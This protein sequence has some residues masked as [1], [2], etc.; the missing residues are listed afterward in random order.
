MTSGCDALSEIDSAIA[1]A[2]RRLARA[3]DAAAAD[4]R[5]LAE[6][7]H[8]EIGVYHALAD[9]RLIH[10]QDDA[11]NGGSLGQVDRRAEELIAAHEA[12]VADLAAARD[13]AAGELER[14]EAARAQAETDV[15][16]AVARHEE[17]A[18]TTRAGLEEHEAYRDKANA[19]EEMTAMA[20]R[21]EQKL[22]LARE[23]RAKKGAAYEAD[24]LFQ[25]LRNRRFAT[26]DYRAFPLFAALDNWVSGLI[27]YREHRLNYE[28][29]LEIPERIAEHVERL[30][31]EAEAARASLEELERDAL[32]KDGVGKLRDAAGAARALVEAYDE[33]IAEAEAH[34]KELLARH[35]DAAAGKAGPLAEARTI[36]ASAL[37]KVAVPDLKVLAA[38]TASPEDDRLVGALIR[39]RRERMEFEEARKSAVGSL[40]ARGR[41]LSELEDIRRRFKSARFDSPYSEFS[42]RDVLAL[43]IAE[44]LSGAL[45]RDELWRRIEKSHKTRRRDWDNDLGGDEWRGPF[46]LPDNW[47]GTMGGSWGRSRPGGVRPPRPPRIPRMPSGGGFRTGGGFGGGSRG[48][49]FRTGG[50]F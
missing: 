16:K 29:L 2:R 21:A 7:D 5:T 20:A 40:G 17:A 8:R 44:F 49:G 34:H 26:R 25:Y 31:E 47:G 4:A 15:A 10:L 36:I 3:S 35:A 37:S 46:G 1:D 13:T 48:G 45:S 50:G 32:E 19:L 11:A 22:A 27:R 39:T 9:I 28:R 14:L 42:G 33:Q 30:K 24:P 12:A 41:R 18:A 38:E 23:D 6:L 43:L